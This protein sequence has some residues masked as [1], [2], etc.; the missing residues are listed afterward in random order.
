MPKLLLGLFLHFVLLYA[1]MLVMDTDDITGKKMEIER[2][3]DNANHHASFAL[4]EDLKRQ[5]VIE[6]DMPKALERFHNRMNQNGNYTWDDIGKYTP[7]PNSVTKTN[8][9][10]GWQYI[11]F[12]QWHD[13]YDVT[14]TMTGNS[15]KTTSMM[16]MGPGSVLRATLVANGKTYELPPKVMTGPSIVAVAYVDDPGLIPKLGRQ[17]IPV[18]SVQELRF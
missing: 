3:I 5:G 8:V 1:G 2:L 10:V 17:I 11:D 18:I 4:V 7:A 6:I 13:S 9:N 15:I 14:L 16:N 12:Q